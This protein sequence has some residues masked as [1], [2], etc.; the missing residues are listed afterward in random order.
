MLGYHCLM[1]LLHLAVGAVETAVI[2]RN[3]PEKINIVDKYKTFSNQWRWKQPIPIF[4]SDHT[5]FKF[6]VYI[7]MYFIHFDSP[8]FSNI[9]MKQE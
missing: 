3:S 1:L 2:D 7:S 6:S 4:G 9:R 5:F 8:H